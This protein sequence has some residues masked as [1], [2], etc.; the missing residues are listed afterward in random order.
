MMIPS[1]TN[2]LQKRYRPCDSKNVDIEISVYNIIPIVHHHGTHNPSVFYSSTVD[3]STESG[4]RT[5]RR[6]K[7]VINV[8]DGR[9]MPIYTMH[10][11]Y[12]EHF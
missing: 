3:I 8:V 9:V 4:I 1:E 12:K 10:L 5:A 11:K 6:S 2:Y 7:H